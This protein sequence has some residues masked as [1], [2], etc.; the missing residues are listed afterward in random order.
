MCDIRWH[1][2]S[3]ALDAGIF[4]NVSRITVH[5]PSG[6][7]ATFREENFE[8][9]K[10]PNGQTYLTLLPETFSPQQRAAVLLAARRGQPP[11][12]VSIGFSD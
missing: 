7:V 3:G 1:H 5:G 12:A 10:L 6:I 9:G 4:P 2:Q 11:V 8:L